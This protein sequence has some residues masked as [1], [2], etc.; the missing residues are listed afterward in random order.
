[1]IINYDYSRSIENNT[2][3]YAQTKIKYG[4]VILRGMEIKLKL[5]EIKIIQNAYL[6]LKITK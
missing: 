4:E 2:I 1:M 5:N 6:F 3:L